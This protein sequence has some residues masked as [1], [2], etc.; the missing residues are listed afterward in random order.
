MESDNDAQLKSALESAAADPGLRDGLSLSAGCTGDSYWRSVRIFESGVAIWG[1]ERQFELTE[2]AITGLLQ[3]LLAAEFPFLP[4]RY[5]GVPEP[6]RMQSESA[7]TVVCSLS[8]SLGGLQKEVVQ[9]NRGEQ[10]ESFARLVNGFLD[11]CEEPAVS[12]VGAESLEEGLEMIAS[13]SLDPVIFEL[14][15]QQMAEGAATDETRTEFIFTLQELT[16]V[17][18]LRDPVDGY[19]DPIE[20]ELPESEVSELAW[21]LSEKAPT[22]LPK[23]LWAPGYTDLSM[24]VLNHEVSL[25]ARPYR[26]VDPETH[27][28]LQ[29]DFD[30][31][32]EL[33]GSL[34]ERVLQ[35]G[36]RLIPEP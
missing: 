29:E 6:D 30:A 1:G 32:V 28:E 18:R 9:I 20:L 15:Y 19:S 4:D 34:H 21:V 31:T 7:R 27:G 5:G 33:L 3:K 10:S 35:E 26:G 16:V 12:G 2:P 36:S 14:Q 11:S 22:R 8:L 25:V 23:N 17:T 13:G 24:R